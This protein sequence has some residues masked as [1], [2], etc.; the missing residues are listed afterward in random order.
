MGTA[1]GGEQSWECPCQALGVPT[2]GKSRVRAERAPGSLQLPRRTWRGDA[3]FKLGV[4]RYFLIKG[5]KHC[6]GSLERGLCPMP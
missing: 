6:K 5:V 3:E 1:R 2:L 4:R